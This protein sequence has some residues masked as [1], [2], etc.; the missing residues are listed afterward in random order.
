MEERAALRDRI[1]T[2]EV[3]GGVMSEAGGGLTF[4]DSA[5]D[6]TCDS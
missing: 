6:E 1:T 4:P 3:A 5:G 2:S